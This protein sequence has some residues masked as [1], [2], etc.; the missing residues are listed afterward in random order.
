MR[1]LQ[2]YAFAAS[3]FAVFLYTG[4]LEAAETYTADGVSIGPA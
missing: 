2:R 4:T 1:I 3:M